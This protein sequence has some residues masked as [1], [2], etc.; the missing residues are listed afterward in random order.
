[1]HKPGTK[2]ISYT[3]KRQA[4]SR[5][6]MTGQTGARSEMTGPILG[7]A[8]TGQHLSSA[9]RKQLEH[10]LYTDKELGKLNAATPWRPPA[11]SPS[12]KGLQ[13]MSTHKL[14]RS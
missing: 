10:S 13:A 9:Q 8:M 7:M 3:P 14:D 5:I 2:V 1:M 11:R 4:R 6:Y 12:S